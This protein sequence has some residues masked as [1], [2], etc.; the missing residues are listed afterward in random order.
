MRMEMVCLQDELNSIDITQAYAEE[1]KLLSA[2]DKDSQL[3]FKWGAIQ[4]AIMA[5]HLIN[6]QLQ[7]LEVDGKYK[8]ISGILGNI[9]GM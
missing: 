1:T 5:R 6:K 3:A 2:L 9:H 8:F 7:S 4:G